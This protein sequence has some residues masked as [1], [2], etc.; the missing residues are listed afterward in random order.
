MLNI[1]A[2][3]KTLNGLKTGAV[4]TG[5]DTLHIPKEIT[6]I[7]NSAF[8][9]STPTITTSTLPSNITTIDFTT[10]VN[11]T[12][13]GYEAFY[14]SPFTNDLVL[15]P[16]VNHIGVR[17]F[18]GCEQISLIDLSSCSNLLSISEAA[19]EDC[20]SISNI[21]FND[22]LEELANPSTAGSGVFAMPSTGDPN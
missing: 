15:P 20:R 18:Y 12:S 17:A 14:R 19:F 10:A 1:S 8:S 2:D 21:I 22:N 13:I 4:I 16:L 6:K 7:V 9:L 5:Y 3:K 11:L